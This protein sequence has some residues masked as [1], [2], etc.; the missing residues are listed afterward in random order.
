M[1]VL[2]LLSGFWLGLGFW[3]GVSGG[4]RCLLG[5]PWRLAGGRCDAWG[6]VPL[7]PLLNSR[8]H[9]LGGLWVLVRAVPLLGGAGRL[10]VGVLWVAVLF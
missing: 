8:P 2:V 3:L 10:L 7:R 6:S 5:G 9:L 1:G 4:W